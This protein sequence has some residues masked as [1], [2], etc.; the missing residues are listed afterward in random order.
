MNRL[1]ILFIGLATLATAQPGPASMDL[2]WLGQAAFVMETSTGLKVLMDP[3]AMGGYR[4]APVEGVDMVTVTHEHPDHNAVDL[5]LGDPTILR[6]L[7]GGDIADVDES[8]EGVRIRTVGSYHDVQH[9]AQRGRNAIFVFELPG[10]KVAHLG[11]LGHLLTAEQVAAVGPVD[12]LL[13][14]VSGGPTIGPETAVE[15]AEQLSARVVVPMHYAT[16]AMGGGGE[17]GPGGRPGG[18]SLGGV[19]AFL[20]ALP[21]STRVID[22]GHTITLAADDLPGER[23]VMVMD[24]E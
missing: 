10:L 6:G 4:N 24:Y 15:V 19:D 21:D 3:V 14:P 2:T 8:V 17:G 20:D 16:A 12:V 9:G 1:I 13:V 11:D 5:A 22:A 18:F 7:D 23:T